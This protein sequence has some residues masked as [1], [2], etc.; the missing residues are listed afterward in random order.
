MEGEAW[1]KQES[2]SKGMECRLYMRNRSRKG[3]GP[4]GRY[5]FSPISRG[6]VSLLSLFVESKHQ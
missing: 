2:L 5:S 3:P 4:E 1:K 6:T